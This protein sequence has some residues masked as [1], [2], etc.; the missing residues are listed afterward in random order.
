MEDRLSEIPSFSTTEPYRPVSEERE[1]M[2][3]R[4]EDLIHELRTPLTAVQVFAEILLRLPPEDAARRQEFLSIILEENGRMQR[5]IDELRQH[6][7]ETRKLGEPNPG[8]IRAQD[9]IERSARAVR[10]LLQEAGIQMYRSIE[11]NLPPFPGDPDKLVQVLVNLVSNAVKFSAAGT[12][13]LVEADVVDRDPFGIQGPFMHLTVRDQGAGIPE[14]DLPHIFERF[15][16]SGRDPRSGEEG[17]G[18]GLSICREIVSLHHGRIWAESIH[19]SGSAFH[20]TLPLQ[21]PG[22]EV[23]VLQRRYGNTPGPEPQTF[24]C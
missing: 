5:M 21:P 2:E 24:L 9:L 4:V 12:T 8:K 10:G 17:T 22:L 7:R 6:D 13:I 1:S 20:V 15:H 14:K 23:E 18:L 3:R 11:E 19:G 16:T